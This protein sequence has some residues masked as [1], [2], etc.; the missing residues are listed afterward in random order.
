MVLEAV[1]TEFA[2]HELA[3]SS[4]CSVWCSSRL[5]SPGTLSS[6]KQQVLGVLRTHIGVGLLSAASQL[7]RVRQR[8]CRDGDMA[9]ASSPDI[10]VLPVGPTY[11]GGIG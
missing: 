8:D 2:G 3:K 1:D 4:V 7:P 5:C 10:C 6:P 11:P 9:D